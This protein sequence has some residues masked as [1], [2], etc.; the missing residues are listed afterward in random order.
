MP[1]INM[2]PWPSGLVSN[3]ALLNTFGSL[4]PAIKNRNYNITIQV[5]YNYG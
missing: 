3:D 4:G 2:T 1:P 5:N